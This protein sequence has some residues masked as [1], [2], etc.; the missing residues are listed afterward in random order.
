MGS[1]YSWV[2]ASGPVSYSVNLAKLGEN[3]PSGFTFFMHL[4]PGIAANR[5]DSDWWE[6]NVV[7]WRIANNADGSAWSD[8]RY[9][10]N[11]PDSNGNMYTDGQGQFPGG[12]GN[13]TTKGIWTITFN[14]N[15]NII[16]TAPGGGT[17]TNNLPPAV[18][19]IFNATPNMQ[20]NVGVV[21]GDLA[22]LGQMAVVTNVKITGTPGEP[23]LNSNFLG[24]PRDTNTWSI[25]ASSPNNGVQ[26]IPAGAY[27]L[28]WTL[29]AQGFSLQSSTKVAGGVWADPTLVGFDGGGKH[30]TLLRQGD[31][32]GSNAG[33]F[34][35]IKR[36][37]FKL[38]VLLP[39]ETNAP[40]TVTGKIGTPTAQAAYVPFSFTVNMVDST[41]HIVSSTDT[42]TLTSSD[43]VFE[44]SVITVPPRTV[45]LVNGTVT[46]EAYLG[47]AGQQTIT[48]TDVTD[49]TMLPNTSSRVTLQ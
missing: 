39:G 23:N 1:N 18:M 22:R 19:D 29:P 26:E 43:P 38:Q 31:L 49:A 45:P 35:M 6:P 14:Q 40:G 48:A 42:V 12:L 47:T 34:R 2:G 10:T 21:P 5:P 41:W 27:W 13:P 28:G 9:K 11:A 16:I 7:M 3:A 36:V 37:P 4:I 44:P 32:P 15:T 8:L 33:F 24:V 25:V 17:V 46:I 30:L 20:I